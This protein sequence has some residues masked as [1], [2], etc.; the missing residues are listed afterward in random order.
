MRVAVMADQELLRV[1][2]A[3]VDVLARIC[4]ARNERPCFSA[5][6]HLCVFQSTFYNIQYMIYGRTCARAVA[7]LVRCQ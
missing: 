3:R 7:T 4:A 6:F 1:A 5:G 2:R